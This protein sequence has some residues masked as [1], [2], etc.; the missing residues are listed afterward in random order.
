MH[1]GAVD[2][3]FVQR[4]ALEVGQRGKA[5]A[6]VVQ[7]K[8]QAQGAQLRHF[9]NHI[10]DVLQHHAFGQFQLEQGSVYA[11]AADGL[12]YLVHVVGLPELPGTD[13]DGDLQV[14]GVGRTS[15]NG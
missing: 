4:Q 12:A 8:A 1:K 7:R 15:P 3:D 5:G 13:V 14:P 11:E 2:L 9:L 6:E 10:V